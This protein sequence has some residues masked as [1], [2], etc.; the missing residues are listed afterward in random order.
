[1]TTR[2]PVQK[3]MGSS[4]LEFG[5]DNAAEYSNNVEW[6]RAYLRT[7]A[8]SKLSYAMQML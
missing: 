4:W 1:M 7:S 5:R 8:Q 3:G 2:D 6:I